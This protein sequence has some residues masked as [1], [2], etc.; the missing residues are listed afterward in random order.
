MS[1]FVIT[2]NLEKFEKGTLNLKERGLLE[3]NRET[4]NGIHFASYHK[5]GYKND[6][7]LSI[8][9]DF[10][11]VIGTFIYKNNYGKNAF[12]LFYDDFNGNIN[13][14][15]L[16]SILQGTIIIKK[17][18]SI[19]IFC[20]KYNVHWTYY[21]NQDGVYYISSSLSNVIGCLN[22]KVLLMNRFLEAVSQ[23]GTMGQ[24]MFYE[25]VKRLFGNETISLTENSGFELQS[26]QYKTN[27]YDF[28]GASRSEIEDVFSNAYLETIEGLYKAFGNE[29]AIHQSGGLDSRLILAGFLKLGYKPKLIYGLG[30]TP[31]TSQYNEDKLIIE[32]ISKKYDLKTYLMNWNINGIIDQNQTEDSFLKYGFNCNENYCNGNWYK[33]YNENIGGLA[34]L[35]LDGH[36]GETLNIE[37]EDGIFHG[38]Y[39]KEFSMSY[40]FDVYQGIFFN[41][42]EWRSSEKKKEQIEYLKYEISNLTDKTFHLPHHGDMMD[43]NEYQKYWWIRYRPADAHPTNLFNEF[44]NSLSPLGISKLHDITL[45]IPFDLIK[46]RAFSI[47]MIDKW[48]PDLNSVGLFSRATLSRIKDGKIIRSGGKK[49]EILREIHKNTPKPIIS[50]YRAIKKVSLGEE[51]TVNNPM[52][53]FYISQL[54]K[55][56]LNNIFDFSNQRGDVRV[57]ATT[58]IY[59]KGIEKLGYDSIA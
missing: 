11:C 19:K 14:A 28:S 26:Y 48:V 40:I 42:Y 44:F 27:E 10:V 45:N 55:S 56:E 54:E 33:E 12:K 13:Q 17:G 50:A 24:Q 58:Y 1:N 47:N 16:D 18:D 53:D 21:F 39:P 9:N 38:N 5:R 34:K 32:K 57:L 29:I 59:W 20:D 23:R 2:N 36:M 7:F 51:K 4:V 49:Y 46:N 22:K 3:S 35:I 37:G 8:E 52:R 41:N 6:N 43:I 15:Q 30:N 31:L 25:G